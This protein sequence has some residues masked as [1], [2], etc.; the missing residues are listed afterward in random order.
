MSEK[1]AVDL[2]NIQKT[3]LLPLWGIAM[4]TRKIKPLLVDNKAVEI[5]EKMDYDFSTIAS[6]ISSLSQTAWILRSKYV[7]KTICEF[8]QKYP[9]GTIVNIGCGLDTNFER[10][11]NGTLQWYDLDMPDV[12]KLRRRF[13]P[14]SDRRV[15][16]SSS[17]L[18]PDWLRQIKVNGNVLF[19]AAGVFY[20]FKE[21]EIKTFFTRLAGGFPGCEV[22]FDASSSYGIKIANKMVIK[23]GGLDEKSYLVWGLEKPED[24]LTWDPRIMVM[25]TL[26]YFRGNRKILPFKIWL[27]GT[28]SDKTRIQ[29]MVHIR[30][31]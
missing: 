17:F 31:A 2:G 20:Y 24:L 8:L 9:S 22:F 23:R 4:E 19:V 18:D 7:D 14:E 10:V 15:F 6:G 25:E 13:I 1:I 16:I 3:L 28:F 5:M 21:E 29:Y 12:V 27:I 11:D 26:Y 30:M